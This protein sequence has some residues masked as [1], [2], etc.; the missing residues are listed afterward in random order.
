VLENDVH[1]GEPGHPILR[2]LAPFPSTTNSTIVSIV[3]RS[4]AFHLCSTSIDGNE[5]TIGWA[6]N[7]RTAAALRL[8]RPAFSSLGTSGIRA[9]GDAGDSLTLDCRFP[10]RVLTPTFH[11]ISSI[12]AAA[13]EPMI[14]TGAKVRAFS[15]PTNPPDI[16]PDEKESPPHF[17]CH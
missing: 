11:Q 5:E 8:R 3:P 1:L 10:R 13:P 2:G 7:G 15:R 16:T 6:G 14:S 12:A 17:P 4:P 9:P